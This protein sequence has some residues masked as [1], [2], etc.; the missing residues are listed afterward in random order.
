MVDLAAGVERAGTTRETPLVT[1]LPGS[2]LLPG[3]PLPGRRCHEINREWQLNTPAKLRTGDPLLYRL[4][5]DPKYRFPGR[6]PDG[7]YQFARPG[8]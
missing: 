6:L 5:T 3:A 2:T 4:L 1:H 7:R 8:P